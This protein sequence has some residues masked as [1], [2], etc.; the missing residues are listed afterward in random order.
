MD[1]SSHDGRWLSYDELAVIRGI[2][3]VSAVKLAQRERWRRQPGNGRTVRVLVPEDWLARY[4]KG[5]LIPEASTEEYREA[6]DYGAMLGAIQAAHA[7]EV[8]ALKA[9]V[10]AATERADRADVTAAA[11]QERAEE[12]A[13]EENT[14]KALGR[15]ARLRAAWRGG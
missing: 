15:W 5:P 1:N 10:D 14:R 9:L 12:L 11:A 8:A 6:P 2:N 4:R 7:G 3:R 13:R